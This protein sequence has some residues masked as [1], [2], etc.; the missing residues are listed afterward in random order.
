MSCTCFS[1]ASCQSP[2]GVNRSAWFPNGKAPG[3]VTLRA[4]ERLLAQIRHVMTFALFVFRR[5]VFRCCGT[6]SV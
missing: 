5:Q 6:A 1:I 2:K 3:E 4:L